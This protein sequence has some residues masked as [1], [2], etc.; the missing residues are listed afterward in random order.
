MNRDHWYLYTLNP[1]IPSL[2]ITK[3]DQTFEVIM[4][5]LDPKKMSIFTQEVCSTG[6][7]ATVMSG[8]DQLIPGANIDE[9]LF[10]PCGYSMNGYIRGVIIA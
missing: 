5:D 4:Q 9:F 1:L 3:P 7:E 8:I 6:P 10:E 2:G